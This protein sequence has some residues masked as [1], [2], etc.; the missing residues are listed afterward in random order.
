[1]LNRFRQIITLKQKT[2]LFMLAL[3]FLLTSQVI[4]PRF[5]NGLDFFIFST[6]RLFSS[7]PPRSIKDFSWDQGKTFYFKNYSEQ[8]KEHGLNNQRLLHSINF[9]PFKD[10]KMSDCSKISKI[11]GS[12]QVFIYEIKLSLADHLLLKIRWRYQAAS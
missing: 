10:I 2:A 7:G 1:M 12:K 4:L 9:G 5:N 8:A 6:W 3:S 11:A